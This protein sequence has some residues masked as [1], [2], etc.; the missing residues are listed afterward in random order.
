MKLADVE[1]CYNL[2]LQKLKSVQ[3]ETCWNET[4]ESLKREA[5]K[6]SQN[7]CKSQKL[8]IKLICHC[9]KMILWNFEVILPKI[10]EAMAQTSDFQPP[11]HSSL[12]SKEKLKWESSNN[13]FFHCWSKQN[14]IFLIEILLASNLAT[15]ASVIFEVRISHG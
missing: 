9:H 5:S 1:T 7:Q 6:I 14:N 10:V 12:K 3:K 8:L 4:Q 2:S 13:H 15:A 11:W